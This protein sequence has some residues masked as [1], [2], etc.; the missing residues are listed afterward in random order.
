MQTDRPFDGIDSRFALTV[1][2][3]VMWPV[4]V[5]IAL[6]GAMWV[7]GPLNGLPWGV[8][9]LVRMTGVVIIALACAGTAAARVADP[10]DR[11]RCLG[12]LAT[13]HLCV[14]LMAL[15]QN[16]AI[17]SQPGEHAVLGGQVVLGIGIPTTWLLY[18]WTKRDGDRAS[19]FISLF[20]SRNVESRRLRSSYE[21]HIRKAAVQEERSRLARDLHDSIKQQLF[22]VQTSAAT[23][24]ARLEANVS[25]AGIALAQIRE[26]A[27]DALTEM[28][29]MLDQLRAAPLENA[30]LIGALKKLAEAT[31]IRTGIDVQCEFG[32]LPPSETLPPGTHADLLRIAQEALSNVA[33]HA[34]A[35]HVTVVLGREEM[36]LVL[37]V[38]DDGKGFGDAEKR[39]GMGLRNMTERAESLGGGMSLTTVPEQGSAIVVAIPMAVPVQP[40]FT[41]KLMWSALVL[42]VWI[43]LFWLGGLRIGLLPF[44]FAVA[45]DLLR[46]LY[47]WRKTRHLPT[48]TA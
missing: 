19:G 1:Y 23:A 6:W 30:G 34:R 3:A 32:D 21:E 37:R 38:T 28:D 42:A 43:G 11:S 46:Y 35:S 8:H 22:V 15:L 10:V 40:D 2:A 7:G 5:F 47:A 17:W 33:R 25:E 27:R 20:Q 44:A 39:R 13:G 45:F 36:A 14:L 9:S 26:S 31:A 12:W 48:I 4:G 18:S 29:T 41:R 16:Q 24:Q